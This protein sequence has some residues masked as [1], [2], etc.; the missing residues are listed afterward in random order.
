MSEIDDKSFILKRLK[1]RVPSI[2]LHVVEYSGHD[3]VVPL[4]ICSKS[5][6]EMLR[7]DAVRSLFFSKS[8]TFHLKILSLTFFA[9]L[10]SLCVRFYTKRIKEEFPDAAVTVT[11]M[12]TRA[13]YTMYKSIDKISGTSSSH[14]LTLSSFLFFH[15]FHSMIFHIDFS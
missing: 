2:A 15:K 12:N 8:H 13:V 5:G 9:K 7:D 1:D 10:Q 14:T 4:R 6:L 11:G 3:S